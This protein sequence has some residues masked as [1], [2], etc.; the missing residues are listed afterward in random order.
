M[1]IQPFVLHNSKTVGILCQRI[2]PLL[3]QW[4]ADWELS[5]V[6]DIKIGVIRHSGTIE[7]RAVMPASLNLFLANCLASFSDPKDTLDYHLFSYTFLAE[8]YVPEACIICSHK[9]AV[10]LCG[11]PVSADEETGAWASDTQGLCARLLSK[12]YGDLLN[13]IQDGHRPVFPEMEDLENKFTRMGSGA[14]AA[15]ITLGQKVF[16]IG[17]S[18]LALEQIFGFTRTSSGGKEFVKHKKQEYLSLCQD[19]AIEVDVRLPPMKARISDLQG[20]KVGGVVKLDCEL[21]RPLDL[22]VD[23]EKVNNQVY[24]GGIGKLRAIKLQTL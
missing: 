10:E 1:T 14:L 11:A 24:L 5:P 2:K 12:L 22:Y 20:L 19:A 4:C 13:R 17:L 15:R 6:S 16:Y 21:D 23:G 18:L 9:V 3:E 8:G 7:G